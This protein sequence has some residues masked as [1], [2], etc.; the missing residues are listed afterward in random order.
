MSV[1]NSFL[2]LFTRRKDVSYMFDTDLFQD[3]KNRV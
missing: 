3:M 2:D 1:I